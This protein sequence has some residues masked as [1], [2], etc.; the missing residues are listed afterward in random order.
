MQ[1]TSLE[2]STTGAPDSP[3]SDAHADFKLGLGD[4]NYRDLYQPERLRQLTAIFYAELRRADAS[5]HADL[6]AYTKAR[7]AN[8]KGTRAESELLIAAAPHLSRFV[9]RLFNVETER[10]AHMESIEAQDAIFKFKNFITR[11]AL[12]RVPPEQALTFDADSLNVA[13]ESFRRAAFPDTLDVDAELGLARMAAHLLAWE[14]KLTKPEVAGKQHNGDDHGGSRGEIG[15][16]RARVAKTGGEV[17]SLKKF[18]IDA[19]GT[20]APDEDAAFVKAALRLLET[21]ASVHATQ[22]AAKA[23]VSGWVSF[24]VPHPLNYEHLVQLERH[25]AELPER[26][27]GLE[28]NLRRRDGFALTDRRASEREV[29]DEVNY[30]LYCHERDKD[31]CSKGLYERDGSLKR[32]PLGIAL[33]GC[34]LDEKISEMHVLQ[35]DGDSIGALALVMIDNPMCPG[36]GHRICNDCMKSCIFQKQEPVN[37]PQ[38]ETGVLTDVLKLP[39]GFEIYSLLTRWNPLNAKRPHALP[40]NGKNILVVGLGPAGYTLA[41]YLLNEGFGVVGIDGLKIEPLNPALTGD[42]GSRVPR[43]VR[44]IA[45]IESP[46]DQR[47]L[48]GFGGVSEYGI[49]V[50]W[51]KNFL[52]MIH[53]TLARRA[54]FRFYGGVRFG[55]TLEIEDAWELGFDHIAIATGAGRPTIVEMRNNLM[56]GIRKASDFLMALQLTGAFKADALANLQVRLPA[57]VIGGGLTAIDTATELFAY[58]PVQVEKILARHEEL[59]AEFGEEEILARFDA[60]ERGVYEEFLAHGRA[61]RGE[62]ERAAAANEAPDFVPLVRAWGGVSIVYRKRLQDSPAYRLNHEEVVKSLEEGIDYI[63]NMS[64]IEAVADE[65]GAVGAI[66]FERMRQDALTR[67]WKASG[68]T[69]RLPARTVCVA[70]GTSPN[71]IYER[72]QP[73]TFK[74]D[75]WGEF[76]APHKIERRAHGD[77]DGGKFRVV[78]VARGERGFFTSY[79]NAGRFVSYYGDNHPVYAGNVVKAMASAKYGYEE[80]CALFADEIAAVENEIGVSEDASEGEPERGAAR[81]ARLVAKLDEDLIARVVRV[82]RLTPTIVDVIVRAPM[83]A[84]KFNPGQFYRLQNYETD[85]RVVRGTKLTMEGLALTGA[86]VDKSEGLLSLIVLEMGAS[87]RQCAQ[88]VPG[89]Q[90][91][92]MGPTGTPTEIPANETVLL[93]GGG[94]GNAV[95]F[96]IAR[97]LRENNCRVVYFA[98]YKKG[99]DLFKREEIE[100]ATDQIVWATD[101]GAGVEP[102]RAQDRHFRGNIVQAMKAYAEGELGTPMFDLRE[103]ERIIAI[104]SDRMMAAVKQARHGVLAEHFNPTHVGVG[105]INSPMQC[106]M[107]EV[108]AQCL[109][110]HVDPQTGAESFVFSCFNQD[111][112]LDQVDFKNLNDR[113]RANTVQEKLANLWLDKLLK[114]AA[115]Q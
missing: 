111:Q 16:A 12:K 34:P 67:K 96:S 86:W 15:E 113:L 7:G 115:A 29:L 92:V 49:T 105:S 45:E 70:A 4:F 89:Q 20:E 52:T 19:G 43:A 65:H 58:Y 99:E 76:F 18:E 48:A 77:E 51:D 102:R 54:N 59:S 75:E 39:Y 11:R 83:Q 88:L 95:L 55:G 1:D 57:I 101:T 66:I 2:S 69:V 17:L 14:E 60:E 6:M 103:V 72:E 35:R 81:F 33:E 94:L 110:R 93:A 107:K 42:G 24:R 46:L 79:E 44:D 114:D 100:A 63:E 10:A 90:V 80:V 41:H 26:M 40:Y 91:V 62:R 61:I 3:N 84:R 56:R 25:D 68:E 30:C 73:G 109:Q 38:A 64:P 112:L 85:A 104:G 28:G 37:I 71:T 106:M 8:L 74:L 32:N 5:L 108:C 53:L 13:L 9:A 22:A 97:A 31:S 78:P 27:R 87:S 82:E 47:V 98:G 36:T 21:W 23:R 50:R